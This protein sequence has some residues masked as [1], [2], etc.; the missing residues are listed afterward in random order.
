MYVIFICVVTVWPNAKR[1]GA[2]PVLTKGE[3]NS[4]PP[5]TPDRVGWGHGHPLICFTEASFTPPGSDCKAALEDNRILGWRDDW[6][7]SRP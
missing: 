7:R 2:G 5:C 1:G 3:Q 6:V 4:H